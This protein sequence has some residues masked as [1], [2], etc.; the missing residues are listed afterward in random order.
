MPEFVGEISQIPP[1]FSAKKIDGKKACDRAR[2]GEKFELKP[3][4]VFC[5]S[6]EILQF[7]FPEIEVK[8]TCGPGFF[9]RALAR[10]FAEKFETAAVAAEIF[11]EKIGNFSVENA[12]EI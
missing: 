10:D 12:V 2:A 4:K 1:R 9:V 5:D 6:I 8:I 7:N 11:R 3:A